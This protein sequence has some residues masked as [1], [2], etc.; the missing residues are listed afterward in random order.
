MSIMPF[1]TVLPVIIIAVIAI[2]IFPNLPKEQS[3]LIMPLMLKKLSHIPMLH[4]VAILFFAATL[5][6]IMSTIDSSNIAI[7]S[8]LVKNVFLK[9][10]PNSTESTV[11][12]F[13]IGISFLLLSSLAYLAIM[14]DGSIWSII[15]LK[16]EI[17]AQ[18]FPMIVLGVWNKTI[19]SLSVLTGLIFGLIITLS[20]VLLFDIPKILYIHAGLWG[21]MVNITVLFLLHFFQKTHLV[22]RFLRLKV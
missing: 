20:L 3:D 8:M 12:L 16:L 2:D 10:Y 17:L 5:S 13:S 11:K 21:V 4:W 7:H 22:K 14:I 15:R 6:A 9:Y 18:L 1:F 19:N